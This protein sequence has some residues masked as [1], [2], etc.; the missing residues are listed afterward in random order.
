[1]IIKDILTED[2][3]AGDRIDLEMGDILIET[4][5]KEV[6]ADGSIVVD[7]DETAL[8][9]MVDGKKA[10]LESKRKKARH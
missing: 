5:I 8:K 9:L 1:M 2:P 4:T 6:L 7:M 10:L 3:Q